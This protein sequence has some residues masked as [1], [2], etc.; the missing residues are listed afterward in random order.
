MGAQ[1]MKERM[2]EKEMGLAER[3]F[4]LE[5]RELSA[6]EKLWEMQAKNY[7]RLAGGGGRGGGAGGAAPSAEELMASFKR[8]MTLPGA[9]EDTCRQ[10]VLRD[11]Y[12]LSQ[13]R[14]TAGAGNLSAAEFG[15][16]EKRAQ[17]YE[18][19]AV[20]ELDEDKRAGWLKKADETRMM[21]QQ[22]QAVPAPTPTFQAPPAAAATAP[23]A[24]RPQA[25]TFATMAEAEAA[26]AAGKIPPGT[27]D[28][29]TVVIIN[30]IRFR[31]D[32]PKS[33]SF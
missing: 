21:M 24:P 20:D 3:K 14:Y 12:I 29:P 27:P 22:G 18:R 33:G 16:L 13:G 15:E 9:T 2:A 7:E 17:H 6:R 11:A 10:A 31:W 25:M 26:A 23:T 32:S 1:A 19:L 4:G 5:E 8:C 30:G 28:N